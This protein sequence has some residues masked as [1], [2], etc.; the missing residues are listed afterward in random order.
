MKKLE[1]LNRQLAD[2]MDSL[3]VGGFTSLPEIGR[4]VWL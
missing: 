2:E 1:K 3:K 4:H